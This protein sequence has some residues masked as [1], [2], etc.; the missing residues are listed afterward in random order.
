MAAFHLPVTIAVVIVSDHSEVF[1]LTILD[2]G[3]YLGV[4]S[5]QQSGPLATLAA[6][7]PGGEYEARTLDC[8]S[9][10]DDHHIMFGI[11]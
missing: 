7:S 3:A 11:I 5:C 4:R 8:C 9:S 10:H 2:M 6:Q 1:S